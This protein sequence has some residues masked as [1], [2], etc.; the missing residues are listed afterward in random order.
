M[1]NERV[2]LPL[3]LAAGNHFTG[4]SKGRELPFPAYVKLPSAVLAPG[5]SQE[6]DKKGNQDGGKRGTSVVTVKNI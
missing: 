6:R 1:L 2:L 4:F 3:G 5:A